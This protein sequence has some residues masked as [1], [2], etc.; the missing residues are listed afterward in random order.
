MRICLG[1]GGSSGGSRKGFTSSGTRVLERVCHL[2]LAVLSV[3]DVYGAV[4][5]SAVRLRLNI[6]RRWNNERACRRTRR[7]VREAPQKG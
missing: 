4:V 6:I 7:G 2:H 3:G 1:L 5:D